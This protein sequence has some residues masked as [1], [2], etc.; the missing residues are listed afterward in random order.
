VRHPRPCPTR[1]RPMRDTREACGW[2]RHGQAIRTGSQF[3]LMRRLLG[4][5][6][7]EGVS[8][9]YRPRAYHCP[10]VHWGIVGGRGCGA[11][12][13]CRHRAD[14]GLSIIRAYEPSFPPGTISRYQPSLPPGKRAARSHGCRRGA[15]C[16]E[17]ATPRLRSWHEPFI[18]SPLE[19]NAAVAA[20]SAEDGLPAPTSH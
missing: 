15:H 4:D 11:V 13:V 2:S 16:R 6:S 18:G 12:L 5:L 17:S 3:T 20:L 10:G 7:D 8:C 9:V 19:S 14:A 1:I